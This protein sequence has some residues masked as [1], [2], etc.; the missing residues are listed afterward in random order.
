[1][2]VHYSPGTHPVAVT[3]HGFAVLDRDTSPALASRIH[4]LLADGRGLGG[5]LEAL[6]GAY[7][8]SLSAVPPF[9]VALAER[10]AVRLAVRGRFALDTQADTAER[11]SGEG[12][13]TW[14]ERVLPDV[15]RVELVAGTDA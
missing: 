15:S 10:G 6:T 14:T 7:G 13:T 5:V 2:S 9:A 4:A 11:I 8:T 3:P 1:M 12:V